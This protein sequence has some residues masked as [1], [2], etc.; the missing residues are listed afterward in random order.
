MNAARHLLLALAATALC[1]SCASNAKCMRAEEAPAPAP[2]ETSTPPTPA[3]EAEAEPEP[4]AWDEQDPEPAAAGLG[5]LAS[6]MEIAEG[7]PP[8]SHCASPDAREAFTSLSGWDDYLCRDASED[9]AGCYPRHAY[10]SR[11]GRGCPG[12][13]LCCQAEH[14]C[15][16]SWECQELGW[17][18]P[19]ADQ[20]VAGEEGACQASARCSAIGTC[21]FVAGA[22]DI[23]DCCTAAEGGYCNANEVRFEGAEAAAKRAKS[24]R[25]PPPFQGARTQTDAYDVTGDGVKAG[26]TRTFG[27]GDTILASRGEGGT[28]LYVLHGRD[29]CGLWIER[30]SATS[31]V[32]DVQRLRRSRWLKLKPNAEDGSFSLRKLGVRLSLTQSS[33]GTFDVEL[34]TRIRKYEGE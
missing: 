32:F 6:G 12:L 24:C 27:F 19:R 34:L 17:C 15:S 30:Q 8:L 25:T 21:T 26:T 31:G 4:I 5:G 7:N 9:E 18:T 29:A 1:A 10:T 11:L 16:T 33:A 20:C 23:G 28:E 14:D 3:P 2:A 13:E 22:D